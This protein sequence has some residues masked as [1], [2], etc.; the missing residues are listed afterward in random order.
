MTSHETLHSHVIGMHKVVRNGM[1]GCRFVLTTGTSNPNKWTGCVRL[2]TNII[3]T[4]AKA[5]VDQPSAI[6]WTI[7]KVVLDNADAI[8]KEDRE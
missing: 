1:I 4:I 8:G 7:V 3:D 5:F 6:G 2:G